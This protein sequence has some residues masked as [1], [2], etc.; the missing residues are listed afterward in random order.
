[1]FQESKP[2]LVTAIEECEYTFLWFTAAACPLKRNMQNDCRV[3][4]PAT[5]KGHMTTLCSWHQCVP[6]VL[7]PLETVL[8]LYSLLAVIA[9]NNE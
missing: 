1:M 8:H 3:T 5:G 9:S 7:E 4:N 2:E 6:D